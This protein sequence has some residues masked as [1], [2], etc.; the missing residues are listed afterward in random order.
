MKKWKYIIILIVLLGCTGCG[1]EDVYKEYKTELDALDCEY[2]S[3]KYGD[4]EPMPYENYR[5]KFNAD[6]NG[7]YMTINGADRFTVIDKKKKYDQKLGDFIL[8]FEEND[9]KEFL[10]AYKAHGC[11]SQIFASRALDAPLYAYMKMTCSAGDGVSSGCFMYKLKKDTPPPNPDDPDAP[12]D[13]VQTKTYTVHSETLKK[14]VTII[15]GYDPDEDETFIEIDGEKTYLD[16]KSYF[17]KINQ[18]TYYFGIAEDDYDGL[19][20][21]SNGTVTWPSKIY[22]GNP[23]AVYEKQVLY[24][25]ADAGK[26]DHYD[27]GTPP[28]GNTPGTDDPGWTPPEQEEPNIDI[29]AFC[30]D[31]RNARTMKFIG[32]ILYIAKIFVPAL[33]IIMGSIDFG[34]A[35]VAG[36][37]DEIKKRIPVLIK[38]F[39]A[40]VLIFFIPVII[41][42]LFQI[43]DGYS[44]SIKKFSNCRTC[45]LDPNNCDLNK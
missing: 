19:F 13:N 2:V 16:A 1:Y 30:D 25:T 7:L 23:V 27:P 31:T 36:K 24:I 10:T 20:P 8:R 44:D 17:Q 21:I 6:A 18:Y 5:M 3:A 38:R 29:S 28:N 11:P 45:I 33:I 22:L 9:L 26:Y 15:L 35:M 40:G 12:V 37:D 41:E 42:F 34:K 39:L 4:Y 32:I 43:L 14:D